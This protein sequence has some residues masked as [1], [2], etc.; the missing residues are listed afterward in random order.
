MKKL[1]LI[2]ALALPLALAIA[3]SASAP[4]ISSFS[5]NVATPRPFGDNCGSFVVLFPQQPPPS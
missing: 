5:V 3:A 2:A 1:V 4:V